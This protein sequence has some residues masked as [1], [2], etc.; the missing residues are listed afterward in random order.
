[1]RE[2]LTEDQLKDPVFGW[3]RYMNW[4][5]RM[6]RSIE[7]WIDNLPNNRVNDWIR[8]KY[9]IGPCCKLREWLPWYIEEQLK[10]KLLW[11]DKGSAETRSEW[12][13]WMFVHWLRTG[14]WESGYNAPILAEPLSRTKNSKVLEAEPFEAVT[15]ARSG[16][17][18]PLDGEDGSGK[19]G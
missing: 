11:D 7:N 17:A 5:F 2:R 9:D 13:R 14:R 12:L 8:Q 1:M 4:W 16:E 6:V 19:I 10:R 18:L 15:G 3:W